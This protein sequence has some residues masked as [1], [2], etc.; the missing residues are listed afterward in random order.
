MTR[1]VE[2]PALDRGADLLLRKDGPTSRTTHERRGGD[3][4]EES[5]AFLRKQDLVGGVGWSRRQKTRNKKGRISI[6]HINIQGG[7]N[8]TILVELEE[9]VS[10]QN[11][12]VYGLAEKHL[13]DTEDPPHIPGY[14]SEVYNR[15]GKYRKE[16][17][18]GALIHGKYLV[19]VRKNC[20][21]H[22]KQ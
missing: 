17:S 14:T 2:G 19:R 3:S 4:F 10:E 18:V 6:G 7:R 5:K 22:R 21:E 8:N 16:G 20:S 9:Q 13:G 1:R 12:K 11:I 15:S